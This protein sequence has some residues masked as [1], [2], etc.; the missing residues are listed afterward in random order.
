MQDEACDRRGAFPDFRPV[1]FCRFFSNTVAG[2][3]PDFNRLP[4][5]P[6][7]LEGDTLSVFI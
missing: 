2:A 1:A 3:A 5:S 4:N 7:S 6:P